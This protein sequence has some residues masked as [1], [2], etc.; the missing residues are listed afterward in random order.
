[1]Y[2]F[3]KMGREKFA[4]Q[5]CAVGSVPKS[6]YME[7]VQ[8][9]VSGKRAAVHPYGKRAVMSQ[10]EACRSASAWKARSGELWENVPQCIGERQTST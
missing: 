10:W 7:G 6:I 8:R 2:P 3:G 1:M 4:P 9:W 5:R